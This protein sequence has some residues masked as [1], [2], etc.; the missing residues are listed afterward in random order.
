VRERFREHLQFED[1]HPLLDFVIT[2]LQ[3]QR[4]GE[5]RVFSEKL[6]A[7]IKDPATRILALSVARALGEQASNEWQYAPHEKESAAFL[8]PYVRDV[9]STPPQ[10]FGETLTKLAAAL[11]VPAPKPA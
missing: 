11:N 5:Q 3:I 2:C 6:H 1:L 4:S 8:D 7:G 10:K 9:V